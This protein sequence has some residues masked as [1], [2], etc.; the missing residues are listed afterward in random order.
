MPSSSGPRTRRPSATR[1]SRPD[2]RTTRERRLYRG[3]A[4]RVRA[5][6]AKAKLSQAE[7]AAKIG[8]TRGAYSN[9]EHARCRILIEYVYGIAKACGVRVQ[10]LLP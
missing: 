3:I 8:L 10:R 9:L 4:V 2:T 7:I 6:R 5:A 1:G